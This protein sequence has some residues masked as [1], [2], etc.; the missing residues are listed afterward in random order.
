MKHV[1]DKVC[2]LNVIKKN[3]LKLVYNESESMVDVCVVI[4][5]SWLQVDKLIITKSNNQMR[6]KERNKIRKLILCKALFHV[7]SKA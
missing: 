2:V 1:R 7:V 5:A 4:V 3:M 6:S